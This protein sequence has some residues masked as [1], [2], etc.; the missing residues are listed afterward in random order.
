MPA[1]VTG[2]EDHSKDMEILAEENLE[3]KVD[4]V[5]PAMPNLTVTIVEEGDIGAMNAHLL[6][7]P[8]QIRPRSRS[9]P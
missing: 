1:V 8:R 5:E 3:V 9:Y 7:R 4:W 2:E 6:N